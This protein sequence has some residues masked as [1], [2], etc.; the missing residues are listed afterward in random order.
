MRVTPPSAFS[1]AMAGKSRRRSDAR[2]HALILAAYA[3]AVFLSALLLFGSTNDYS[4]I[5]VARQLKR[6]LLA[7]FGG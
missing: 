7:E 3:T 6:P 2:V 5:A 1:N 4:N